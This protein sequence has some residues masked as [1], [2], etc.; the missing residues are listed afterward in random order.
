MDERRRMDLIGDLGLCAY[1][2]YALYVGSIEDRQLR[3][4]R[5]SCNRI[6]NCSSMIAGGA[7]AM[8]QPSAFIV[9]KTLR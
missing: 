7:M 3:D 9:Y 6:V 1:T 8:P 5:G 4:L 2:S